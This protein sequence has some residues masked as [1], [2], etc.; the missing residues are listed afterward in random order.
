MAGAAKELIDDVGARQE[1]SERA[2]ARAST[3]RWDNAIDA[4]ATVLRSVAR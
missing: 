1:L 4:Y 2:I 3:F